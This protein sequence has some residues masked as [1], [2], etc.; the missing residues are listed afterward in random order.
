LSSSS[1]SPFLRG[2]RLAAG[3]TILRRTAP[4]A[5]YSVALVAAVAIQATVSARAGTAACAV[6]VA[7][8]LGHHITAVRDTDPRLDPLLAL[9]LVA[10]AAILAVALPVDNVSAALWPAIVGL[11]LLL[12]IWRAAR[13]LGLGRCDLGLVAGPWRVQAAIAAGGVPLGLVVAVALEPEPLS[14]PTGWAA[15]A[16]AAIAVGVFAGALE[17]LLMRGLLQPLVVRALG[18]G[19]VAWTAAL[20]A[21]L[22]LGSR[23][24]PVVVAAGALGL[25]F[26]LVRRQTGSVAGIAGAHALIVAGALLIW[27]Q[28]LGTAPGHANRCTAGERPAATRTLDERCPTDTGRRAS[29]GHRSP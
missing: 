1:D 20:T 25:V 14:A 18:D 11:P 9:A 24:A 3:A 19:G 27:P 15:F 28:V 6:L 7:V 16:G 17:E 23:S 13:R 29:V 21:A 26:G 22:Y 12:G 2:D 4:T 10:L 5:R 8:L